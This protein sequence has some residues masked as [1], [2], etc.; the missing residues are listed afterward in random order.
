[1][2]VR[3]SGYRAEVY[4]HELWCSHTFLTIRLTQ[5]LDEV[6]GFLRSSPTETVIIILKPDYS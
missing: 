3:V 6:S 1:M 5:L 2:D 4:R